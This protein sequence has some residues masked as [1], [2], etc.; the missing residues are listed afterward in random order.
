M[1]KRGVCEVLAI[2]AFCGHAYGVCFLECNESMRPLP[3][4]VPEL[5][6]VCSASK[7]NLTSVLLPR[8]CLGGK[9]RFR[10]LGLE[11]DGHTSSNRLSAAAQA[12]TGGES[13]CGRRVRA[14][15]LVE[16]RFDVSKKGKLLATVYVYDE[17]SPQIAREI[18]IRDF[19]NKSTMAADVVAK[20]I[21]MKIG[22]VG[23]ISFSWKPY[24]DNADYV[25]FVRGSAA[26]I[27]Q[28]AEEV[29]GM[30]KLFDDILLECASIGLSNAQ[31][32]IADAAAKVSGKVF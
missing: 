32:S 14:V 29:V 24:G 13:S 4:A 3:L 10:C 31:T 6:W 18:A 12:M 1:G 9:I 27:V 8:G 23:N 19:F 5:E 22:N 17:E 16:H 15:G 20:S 30:A 26:V 25:T 21:D 28:G 11:F 7:T 2:A